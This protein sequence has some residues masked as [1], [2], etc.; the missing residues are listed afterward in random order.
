MSSV[1]VSLTFFINYITSKS[2]TRILIHTI[3]FPL[4][5]CTKLMQTKGSAF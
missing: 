5:A 1:I 2:V 4:K 3:F